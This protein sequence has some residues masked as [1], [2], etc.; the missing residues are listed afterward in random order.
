MPADSSEFIVAP[1]APGAFRR[2]GLPSGLSFVGDQLLGIV[3]TIVMGIVG[4]DSLAAITGATTALLVLIV[5]IAGF[6]AGIRIL[7]AQAIGAGDTVRFGR[8]TRSAGLVNIAIG[9]LFAGLSFPL[10]HPLMRALVGP[11]PS[12]DAGSAYLVLRCV[13]LIPLAVSTIAVPAFSA[14]GDTALALRLLIWI[15]AVHVPLVFVLA[16]GWLT[17]R[18]MG[19]IGAGISSLIAEC[20]GALFCIVAAA[21]SPQLRIFAPLDVDL[22]LL[23]RSTVL[24]FPEVVFLVFIILPDVI[25]VAL[26]APLGAES[27]AAYRALVIVSDLTFGVPAALGD[28]SEIVL[29]QRF[30]AGDAEGARRFYREADRLGTLYSTICGAAV[31][32]LAWPLSAL[33]TLNAALANMAALPLAVHMVTLPLK[34]WSLQMIAP[35]RAGGDT[36]FAMLVGIMTS[37]LVIPIAYVALERFHAG[38]Y[39]IA[40][41][42]TIAW[43]TRCGLT[44][45]RLR[46]FDWMAAVR[47]AAVPA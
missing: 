34:G 17:G 37:A 18:P 39:A 40:I 7:G 10:A 20:I 35:V 13:S 46:A 33:F 47:A 32:V 1:S 30:G 9:I 6:G 43:A 28:A 26:I 8:I 16:L 36:R 45:L 38:L 29:A 14:A 11:L 21:R 23:W 5:A 19:L 27:L 15:N 4:V 44:V 31:A 42:W 3:D 41:S 2:L 25:I 24:S 22:A 12:L